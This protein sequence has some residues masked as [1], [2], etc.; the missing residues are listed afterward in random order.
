V[1]QPEKERLDAWISAM[2]FELDIELFGELPDDFPFDFDRESL[3]EL[4]KFIL[5]E[6]ENADE[7]RDPENGKLVDRLTRYIGETFIRNFE[8]A[9]WYPG[10]DSYHNLPV[11]LFRGSSIPESPY[12]L[13]AR[14]VTRRTG[15][16]LTRVYDG[17]I[18]IMQDQAAGNL[19]IDPD[20]S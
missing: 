4:E 3:I 5:D 7:V 14:I 8:G 12:M 13:M 9:R 16:C 11:V 20:P 2:E 19:A 1:D 17:R 18:E 10:G 15:N 6:F